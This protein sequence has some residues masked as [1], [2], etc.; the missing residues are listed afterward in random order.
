MRLKIRYSLHSSEGA[1]LHG[2]L[3][4]QVDK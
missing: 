4:G 1:A 3:N 2:T